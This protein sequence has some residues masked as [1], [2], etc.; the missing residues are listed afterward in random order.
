[1][2]RA[3]GTSL[4]ANAANK[5]AGERLFD[6]DQLQNIHR[7]DIGD[8]VRVVVRFGGYDAAGDIRGYAPETNAARIL[9]NRPNAMPTGRS[10]S[11]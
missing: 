7:I 10:R 6:R 3:D 8:P 2:G 1:L 5:F 4:R 9:A 11:S